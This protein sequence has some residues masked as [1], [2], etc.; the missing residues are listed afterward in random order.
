MHALPYILTTF[1]TRNNSLLKRV[2]TFLSEAKRRHGH[3]P[4]VTGAH[5]HNQT[6]LELSDWLIQQAVTASKA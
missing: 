2:K 1:E 6:P 3:N 4:V 5:T